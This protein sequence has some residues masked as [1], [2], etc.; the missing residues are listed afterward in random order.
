M[1]KQTGHNTGR[2]SRVKS[3]FR[4]IL[5]WSIIELEENIK[6]QCYSYN[7][8]KFHKILI[9]TTGITD[10]KPSK[11]VNFHEQR[12]TIPVGMVQYI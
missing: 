1:C 7:V 8:T 5:I 11:I 2:L 6:V 9:K 4:Q 3:Y 10:L 12:A